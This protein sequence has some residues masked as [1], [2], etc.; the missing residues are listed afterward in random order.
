MRDQAATPG[1]VR[2]L[3]QP[4]VR[5]R[6][7]A[8]A[9]GAGYL[10]FTGSTAVRAAVAAAAGVGLSADARPDHAVR[11]LA[12]R[13]GGARIGRA[14]PRRDRLGRVRRYLEDRKSTRLNSSH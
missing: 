12:V 3:A 4:G 13:H 7:W 2:P 14:R 9:Q 5:L 11:R 6:F 8:D 10:G 1:L